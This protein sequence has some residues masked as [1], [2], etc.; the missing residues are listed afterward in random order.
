MH[1]LGVL[2]PEQLP[3]ILT[4]PPPH[5]SSTS[6]SSALPSRSDAGAHVLRGSEAEAPQEV[7]VATSPSPSLPSLARD[8]PAGLRA[9]TVSSD[10]RWAVLEI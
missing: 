10:G 9:A 7:C 2:H 6:I 1:F 8:R 3:H 4:Q 5:P